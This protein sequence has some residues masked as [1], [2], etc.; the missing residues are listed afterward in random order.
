MNIEAFIAAQLAKPM[1]HK[2]VVTYR[3]G[4]VY[5][6]E[7]RSLAQAQNHAVLFQRRVGKVLL[8]RGTNREK[9]VT[10]VEVLPL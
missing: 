6:F 10:S 5:V 4:E 2:V 9:I 1:T 7:T 8:E 3:D